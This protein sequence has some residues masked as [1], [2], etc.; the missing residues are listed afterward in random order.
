MAT[1]YFHEETV[2]PDE[3]GNTTL[4]RYYFDDIGSEVQTRLFRLLPAAAGTEFLD[5]ERIPF[6]D[7]RPDVKKRLVEALAHKDKIDFRLAS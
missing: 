2:G 4:V 5:N 6:A 3:A 7:L 1:F